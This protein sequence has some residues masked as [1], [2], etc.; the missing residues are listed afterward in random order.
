MSFSDRKSRSSA[1][2]ARLFL[3]QLYRELMD[4]RQEAVSF[5]VLCDRASIPATCGGGSW[6]HS[7]ARAMS[8]SRRE[9]RSA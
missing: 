6:R 9:V 5:I 1:N 4:R 8:S 3:D 7:S 2:H